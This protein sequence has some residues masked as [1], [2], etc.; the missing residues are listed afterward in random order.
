MNVHDLQLPKVEYGDIQKQKWVTVFHFVLNDENLLLV[1]SYCLNACTECGFEKRFVAVSASQ[2]EKEG[3][4][5]LIWNEGNQR[6]EN[7][8]SPVVCAH[9]REKGD[10]EINEAAELFQ[11]ARSI[12]DSEYGPYHPNTLGVY[13]N[14]AGTYDALGRT[15]DAIEILEYVVGIREEKLGT[16]NP[17]VDG[18]KRRLAK[19]L[20]E[21]GRVRNRKHM[22]LE[23]LLDTNLQ[24]L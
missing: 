8:S 13:S 19:I 5:V 12:F 22:S 23:T 7:Q 17:D 1:S 24:F 18:E 4:L 6:R 10:E 14:L 20:K 11:E 16:A 15:N 9:E 21:G 3:F 2:N